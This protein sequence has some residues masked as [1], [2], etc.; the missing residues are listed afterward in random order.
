[1]GEDDNIIGEVEFLPQGLPPR[2][3]GSIKSILD[4]IEKD[5]ITL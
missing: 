5:I 4:V 1:L 2:F 3:E